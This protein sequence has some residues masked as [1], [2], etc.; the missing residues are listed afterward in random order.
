MEEKFGRVGKERRREV[1]RGE[2]RERQKEVR[3]EGVGK[4]RRKLRRR[5]GGR[6]RESELCL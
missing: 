3:E 6:H 2:R 5:R 4:D 1:G